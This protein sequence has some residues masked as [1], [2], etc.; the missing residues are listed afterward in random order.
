[1]SGRSG[2]GL[3]LVL[4]G[5]LAAVATGVGLW[6]AV[7]FMERPG[8]FEP[9]AATYLEGGR[10]I[11]DFELVDHR[12]Q[13]FT[14][15]RFE[16]TWTVVGFG[17][18]NCPDVCPQMLA[19]LSASMQHWEAAG[20][21]DAIEVAFVSVDPERDTVEQLADYVPYFDERFIGVTGELPEI[22]AF[23]QSVGIAHQRHG[24]GEDYSVDHS[25]AVLLINPEGK[26]QA[27]FTPPHGSQALAEDVLA[28]RDQW[29]H[30]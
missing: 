4:L 24:E 19:S 3:K 23:T 13:A 10:E 9:Q 1:M 14:P 30:R 12:E 5:G 6:L 8:E 15:G 7:W 2:N 16:G 22:N 26:L 21:D 18:T 17:F 25:S 28:I 29:G 27:I 20:A 11:A